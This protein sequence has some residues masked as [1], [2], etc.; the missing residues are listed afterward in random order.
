MNT[1]IVNILYRHYIFFFL[2]SYILDFIVLTL[3][4]FVQLLQE[5][6]F[7]IFAYFLIP[8]RF[9]CHLDLIPHFSQ[10]HTGSLHLF[11]QFPDRIA[12]VSSVIK[13]RVRRIFIAFIHDAEAEI[14]F[15]NR[16]FNIF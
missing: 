3:Y 15:Y 4:F 14:S 6:E 9:L 2:I 8:F 12:S 7:I 16:L 1:I 5:P 11:I 13:G 10:I